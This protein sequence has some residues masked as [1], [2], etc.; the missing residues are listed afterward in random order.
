VQHARGASVLERP[1][2]ERDEGR[3]KKTKGGRARAKEQKSSI[4]GEPDSFCRPVRAAGDFRDLLPL[5]PRVRVGVSYGDGG[6]RAKVVR[7]DGGEVL[8][9][10]L[11]Q[12]VPV[13]CRERVRSRVE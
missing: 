5:P 6:Q 3:Y 4:I 2:G 12:I 7:V 11:V 13:Q 9:S 8:L 10:F 1:A